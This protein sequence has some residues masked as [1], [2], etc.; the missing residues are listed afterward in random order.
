MRHQRTQLGALA[1]AMHITLAAVLA[2]DTTPT[3]PSAQPAIVT[4]EFIYETAPFP[5]CHASTLAET[6]G[7]LVAAWFGGTYEKHPDVGIWFSRHSDGKWTA[8]VEVANGVEQTGEKQVRYPTWNPVLFQPKSGPLMLFYKVGPSPSAWWGMLITSADGG[9]TWSQP[10][11]LPKGILGP[12]KNKPIEMPDGEL[13]CPSSTES[14]EKPSRWQ[15]DFERTRDLGGTWETTGPLNDGRQFGAIQPS[16]LTLPG[17]KLKAVGRTRQGKIFQIASDDGGKT[18]G[19]MTATELPNPN[20]GIDAVTLA[21]GRHLIVYNHTARGRSPLNVALSAD[22]TDWKPALV[23][24]GQPGEYSYPAVI[25]TA[26]GLVHITYTWQRKRVRHVVVDPAKLVSGGQQSSGEAELNGL[27]KTFREEFI[28]ITPGKDGFPASFLMGDEKGA[29]AERPCHSVSIARSFEIAR[30]EVPQNLWEAVMGHNPSRWQGKRNSVEMLS[31]DDAMDFC[32]RATEALRRAKLI[33]AGEE[34]RL[35]S[36]AEWEYAARAGS[37]SRYSFGDDAG[38]LDD[39]GWHHG[40]AAGNDPPVGAK[41]PN[42]WKLYDMHGYLWEWCADRWHD[43]YQGAPSDGS[44]WA[45][46]GDTRRVLRG[47]SWKDPAER[48]T[49]AF[50]RAAEPT[51]RDDAVGL[52]CVLSATKN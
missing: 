45:A 51:L 44:A 41:R 39:Y 36:E 50:R 32:R 10:R 23:L 33:A 4:R 3:E 34:I 37:T 43:N 7:T 38:E 16:I 14:T 9:K 49:S 46:G 26:D 52:R 17:G 1:L 11:R 35:P 12:I 6:N 24:E 25:Q 47:G 13:L 29:D 27:L 31:Y 5:E 22:A 40:N 30:Y 18:W 15:I 20:S 42:A 2:A 19:E 48:L 28:A 21:D 8:P